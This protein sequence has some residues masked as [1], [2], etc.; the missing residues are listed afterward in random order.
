M[1]KM[2]RKSFILPAIAIGVAA[3][4]GCAHGQPSIST[5]SLPDGVVNQAYSQQLQGHNVDSWFI[6]AGDAPT[7]LQLSTSGVL[8]GTPTTAGTFTF[9]VEADSGSTY[10]SPSVDQIFSITITSS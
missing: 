5:T 7:G 9:T 2:L 8:S 4:S 6:V 10:G 1:V 3:I